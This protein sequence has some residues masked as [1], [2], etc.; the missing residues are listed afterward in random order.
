[1][2]GLL[3]LVWL[4]RNEPRDSSVALEIIGRDESYFNVRSMVVYMAKL[5]KLL[6]EDET[7]QIINLHGSGF[8]LITNA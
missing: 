2:S 4:H 3:R 1:V 8:K 7:V 5:R 6:K